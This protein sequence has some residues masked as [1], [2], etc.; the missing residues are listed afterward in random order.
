[1]SAGYAVDEALLIKRSLS[2]SML[3]DFSFCLADKQGFKINLAIEKSILFL[4]YFRFALNDKYMA[5]F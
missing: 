4:R 3:I 2:Q 5:K 1:M